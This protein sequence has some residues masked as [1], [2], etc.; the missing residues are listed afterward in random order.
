[1][2]PKRKDPDA[3]RALPSINMKVC[4]YVLLKLGTYKKSSR[5]YEGEIVAE[6]GDDYQVIFK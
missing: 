5:L 1:M 6:A 4:V 3:G 2:H